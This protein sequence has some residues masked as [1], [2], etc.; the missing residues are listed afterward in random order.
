VEKIK[1]AYHVICKNVLRK[2][3]KQIH[4]VCVRLIDFDAEKTN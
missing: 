1:K 2:L 4:L 3:N